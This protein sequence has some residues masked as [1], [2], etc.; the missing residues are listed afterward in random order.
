MRTADAPG[1]NSSGL[2][3]RRKHCGNS[4]FFPAPCPEPGHGR[5]SCLLLSA[6]LFDGDKSVHPAKKD[7]GC[8]RRSRAVFHIPRFVPRDQQLAGSA[9]TEDLDSYKNRSNNHGMNPVH[10]D[11]V[12]LMEIWQGFAVWAAKC[13]VS[14]DLPGRAARFDSSDNISPRQMLVLKTHP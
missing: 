10:S 8:Q 9:G 11:R 2:N 14:S 4:S 12:N 7:L 5:N 3:S 1:T 13:N 6:G